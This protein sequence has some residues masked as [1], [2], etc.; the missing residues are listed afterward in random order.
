L[1][2]P[3]SVGC[4]PDGEML[5]VGEYGN[6]RVQALR[7]RDG[8]HIYTINKYYR[9]KTTLCPSD[10]AFDRTGHVLI[11]NS[12]CNCIEVFCVD[13]GKYIRSIDLSAP[14]DVG[15]PASSKQ[16]SRPRGLAL[17]DDLDIAITDHGL[18]RIRVLRKHHWY[19]A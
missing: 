16:L 6:L 7:W 13:N 2:S 17:S 11:V 19:R 8:Q 1:K 4:T 15:A 9:Q 3:L 5:F 18:N 12:D 14:S 10:I